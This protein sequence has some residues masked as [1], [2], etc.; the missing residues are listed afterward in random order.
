M[1][2]VFDRGVA[3]ATLIL[4]APLL[5]VLATAVWLAQTAARRCSPRSGSARTGD[6]FRI[7]KFRTMVTDDRQH[8]TELLARSDTDGALF[9]LNRDP[10]ITPLGAHLRRWSLDELPQLFNVL[11]GDMSLVG[12]RPALSRRSSELRRACP[13]PARGKTRPDWPVAGKWPIGPVLGRLHPARPK[14]RREL[15]IH[16]GH[17]HHLENHLGASTRN[18][19]V[20]AAVRHIR[21]PSAAEPETDHELV[22]RA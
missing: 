5:A 21:H 17:A 3:A 16:P 10:R 12:P 20:L 15:D 4:L 9:K 7:Y 13:P 1:K 2:S 19:R 8:R 6:T 18:R 14:I 11:R 22:C